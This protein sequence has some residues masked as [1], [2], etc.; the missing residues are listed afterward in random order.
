MRKEKKKERDGEKKR[1][2]RG[3]SSSLPVKYLSTCGETELLAEL[4]QQRRCV[5][6]CVAGGDGAVSRL[7]VIQP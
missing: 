7:V 6:V 2:E 3:E 4:N 1:G 5:C